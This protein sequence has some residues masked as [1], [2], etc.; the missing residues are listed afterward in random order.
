MTE[1][2]KDVAGYEG[3]YWVSSE[4]RV[5]TSK[6]M[7]KPSEANRYSTVSLFKDGKNKT[8]PVHK[9]V[10]IAFLGHVQSGQKEIVDHLNGDKRDNRVINLRLTDVRGNQSNRVGKK[11]G[12]YTSKYVGVGWYKPRKCWQAHISHNKVRKHLGFFKSEYEA[13]LAY[14]A[15]LQNLKQ[16]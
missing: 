6:Q 9:L 1:I 5:K 13:H 14:Q 2:W 10:A 8:I 16:Q 3:K 4:G 15:E 7:L 12:K 11:T